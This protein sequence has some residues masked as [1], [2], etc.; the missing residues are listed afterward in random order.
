[1]EASAMRFNRR[2]FCRGMLAG[3]SGSGV[4]L[5]S[6]MEVAAADTAREGEPGP[7]GIAR[8]RLRTHRLAELRAFY[9]EKLHFPIREAG[10]PRHPSAASPSLGVPGVPGRGADSGGGRAPGRDSLTFQAGTTALTFI[11][12]EEQESQP[13]Y[14]F[15][16]NIPENKLPLAKEWLA[17]R[18]PLAL[19]DGEAVFHF[20]NWNAH[21]IY[22]WD[23]AG[24]LGELIARHNLP[25][26]R[27]GAFTPEEI[28][29]ASEIG[30]VVEDVPAAVRELKSRLGLPTYRQGSNVFEPVGDEHRL[31]IVAQKGRPW[32]H[33]ASE[34]FP[35][36]AT[37]YGAEAGQCDLAGYPY[38]VEIQ[39]T[40]RP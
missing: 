22:F 12:T 37:L 1:M 35:T 21:S 27:S 11:Q 32:M 14:H 20:P 5:G 9:H 10:E 38:A 26:A 16:F 19:R 18:T 29:H 34:I 40:K 7:L 4:A 25:N 33:R 39:S 3:L 8:L 13:F 23:P 36:V 24:N 15:A 2:E 28:L 6:A 30:L 17:K 31:L